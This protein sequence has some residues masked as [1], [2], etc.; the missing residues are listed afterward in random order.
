MDR[1]EFLLVGK[2]IDEFIVVLEAHKFTLAS[3]L[4]FTAGTCDSEQDRVEKIIT[5]LKNV[6]RKSP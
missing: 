5:L 6:R 1:N 4:V 2:G 3:L